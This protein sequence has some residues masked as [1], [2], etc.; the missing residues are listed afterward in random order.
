MAKRKKGKEVPQK[1]PRGR[2]KRSSNPRSQPKTPERD[3][4]LQETLRRSEEK[5][6][7]F[8]DSLVIGTIVLDAETM[9]IVMVNEV[10]AKVFGFSSAEEAIGVN[11]L[12]LVSPED[13]ERALEI[14]GRNVSGQESQQVY[15]LRAVTKGGR[16]IWISITG[17]TI[18]HE[19]KL[20]GLVSFTDITE[21]KQAEERIRVANERLEYLIASASVVIYSAEAHGNYA[22]TFQAKNVVQLTGYEPKQ[23]L[24]SQTFWYEHVHPDDRHI[25][26]TEVPKLFE[27]DFHAYEYRFQRKDGEYIWVRD[28]MKLIRDEKGKPS[29][30]IGAWFDITERKKAEEAL[31]QSG[32]RYRTVLDEMEEGYY[33][34]DTAGNF[35]FVN[36]AMS[37]ILGYSRDELIGMNYKTYIPNEH[38]KA[39]FEAY[40]RVYRTGEPLNWCPMVETTK[41]GSR[42]LVED[43]VL[44]L[45]NDKGEVIGFRGV[46]RDVTDRKR[47]E[48]ALKQSEERYRTILEEM[49]DAYFEVDLGG[50]LT[51]VNTSTC[52]DLG[53]SRE[54]LIGMSYKG[55]TVEEDIA[56]VFRVFNEVYRTGVPNK[57]FPWKVIRKDDAQG[58]VEASI[59]TLRDDKGEIIGF[60]GV[61]RDI[62]E[63][64]KIEEQLML[65]D[66]LASIGR[67]VAGAAHE[68]NNPL[69]AVIGFSDLLLA[70]DLASDVKADLYIV[71]QEA[72]RAAA[73]VKELLAF[74]REQK[75]EK[76]LVNINSVIQEVL[77]EHRYEQRANNIEVD[78][79]LDP[80]LPQIM[81]NGPQLQK[82]FASIIT[83]AEQAMLEA[84]GR[85]RLT[86]STEQV[87]NTV[88]V[89]IADD[90]LGISP[91][92]MKKLFTPFFTTREVGE[93]SGLGLSVC[94]GIVTEHGGKIY[95]TS[96]FGKGATF[97][98]ELPVGQQQ[99]EGGVQ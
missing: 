34:V 13:R 78:V 2:G 16:K 52:R 65:A 12:D 3:Q 40:N 26:D 68:L 89:S 95:A 46:S 56:S 63:R 17:A 96:E 9:K 98:V 66:R 55:F 24:E 79:R 10:A 93:G 21:R 7:A 88:R 4:Q 91:D 38:V 74:A 62:T 94:H 83:N 53:Y 6:R 69:T 14:A 57:G 19:G 41:D 77:Q 28:E 85:G 8:F 87:G 5:Y 70:R 36:D 64:R 31:R 81:G 15:E 92:N 42:L 75:I 23:F 1:K 18:M 97:V 99:R 72:K 59:S 43:S 39:V 47:T 32:E 71:N 73:I 30:I 90:G 86:I 44:A 45:R 29:E 80:A 25:V 61:G 48:E 27:N 11:P 84:H 54:E 22:T 67:L 37:R 49:A 58:L 82:V 50:Y 35:T 51:F 33:E 76:T 20:A 60:R